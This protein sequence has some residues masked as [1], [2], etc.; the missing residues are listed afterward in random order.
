MSSPW[1]VQQTGTPNASLIGRAMAIS[2]EL[3]RSTTSGRG[4]CLSPVYELV[5]LLGLMTMSSG[6]DRHRQCPELFRLRLDTPAGD[7]P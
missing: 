4:S 6:E 1:S 5:D 3:D 7:R 2:I